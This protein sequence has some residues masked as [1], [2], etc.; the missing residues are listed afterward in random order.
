MKTGGAVW[1]DVEIV[2]NPEYNLK[3]EIP[4]HAK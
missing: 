1:Y 4:A 2:F 3:I